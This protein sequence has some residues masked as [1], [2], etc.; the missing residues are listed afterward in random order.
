MLGLWLPVIV[1]KGLDL[2]LGLGG[3]CPLIHPN[4]LFP[5]YF[6]LGLGLM[7]AMLLAMFT[8]SEK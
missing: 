2:W 3:T 6:R 8:S 7:L 5:F 4:Y 1:G